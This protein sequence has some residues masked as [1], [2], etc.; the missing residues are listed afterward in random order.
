MAEE[1]NPRTGK[2]YSTNPRAVAARKKRAARKSAE[3]QARNEAARGG[4]QTSPEE[5]FG[6]GYTGEP[7]YTGDTYE[8]SLIH[9]SEPTRPY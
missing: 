9:I 6:E 3:A 4:E 8:L 7:T 5:L 2:P 1:I